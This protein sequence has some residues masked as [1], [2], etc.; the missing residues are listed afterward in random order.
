NFT[1]SGTTLGFTLPALYGA[2][3]GSNGTIDPDTGVFSARFDFTIFV[4]SCHALIDGV[5]SPDGLSFTATYYSTCPLDFVTF[6]PA[7]VTGGRC[8]QGGVACCGNRLIEPDELCD[9]LCCAPG[10]QAYLASGSACTS[11]G[12]VCTDDVCDG[13]GGCQHVPNT[14]L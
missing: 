3:V 8:G 7:P 4:S 14:A 2:E 13:A 12:N 5:A 11:D 1:Q 10:C 6:G 9:A